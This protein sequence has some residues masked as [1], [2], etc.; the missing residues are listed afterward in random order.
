LANAVSIVPFESDARVVNAM[1]QA[2]DENQQYVDQARFDAGPLTRA[3]KLA[4]DMLSTRAV[5]EF[6]GLKEYVKPTLLLMLRQRFV[7]VI[8]Q[9]G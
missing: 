4:S 9:R 6:A 5:L 3:Y 7:P 2:P 8:V 1:R